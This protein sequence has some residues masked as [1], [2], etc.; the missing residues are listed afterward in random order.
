MLSNRIEPAPKTKALIT[1]A[2]NLPDEVMDS[3]DK[4]EL[5]S[6]QQKQAN[7]ECKCLVCGIVC[8]RS[9][10]VRIDCSTFIFVWVVG[11]CH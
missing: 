9:V 10:G 5:Q 7:K 3:T 6:E 11:V 4:R 1:T 8:Q 2:H